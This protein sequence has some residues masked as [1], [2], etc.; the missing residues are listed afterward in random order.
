MEN[1]YLC[2]L[3]KN[4]KY[5]LSDDTIEIHIQGGIKAI[6]GMN[7][8]F[9]VES[10]MAVSSPAKP[11]REK[12]GQ[13]DF[14]NNSGK[15][16]SFSEILSALKSSQVETSPST[17]QAPSEYRSTLYGRD[18]MLSCMHYRTREYHY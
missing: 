12:K 2:K 1:N 3:Q 15:G 13:D 7:A 6:N 9:M 5:K 8:V 14:E 18:M 4:P 17:N 10:V 16:S 11:R